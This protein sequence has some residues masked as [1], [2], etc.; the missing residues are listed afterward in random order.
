MVGDGL[1]DLHFWTCKK[2]YIFLGFVLVI[3][4]NYNHFVNL[5]LD[6]PRSVTLLVRYCSQ[7]ALTLRYPHLSL[8]MDFS[9]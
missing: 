5:L 3:Q 6:S 8:V 1:L 2:M 4:S 7:I 9:C